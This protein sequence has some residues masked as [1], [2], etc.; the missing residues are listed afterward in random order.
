MRKETL[1]PTMLT[2]AMMTI[3]QSSAGTVSRL[4]EIE[5]LLQTA[6]ATDDL[7]AVKLRLAECVEKIREEAEAVA[8]LSAEAVADLENSSDEGDPSRPESADVDF[9]TGLPDR[10]VAEKELRQCAASNENAFAVIFIA[11]QVQLINARFG[12]AAG[13]QVLKTAKAHIEQS[14]LPFDRLYRW[15]GPSFL[16]LLK[17]LDAVESVR[18]EVSR[19]ATARLET[20]VEM[21][22]KSVLIPIGVHSAV[23]AV[24]S[25]LRL[26]THRID[27]LVA[28]HM[29]KAD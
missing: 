2:K 22:N 29:P 25:P 26:L 16:A 10:S 11:E 8:R 23:F 9:T 15:R 28:S 14:L 24:A 20:M 5:K 17:R 6:A 7:R 12:Y 3:S 18:E 19:I 4:K 21:G 13:D 27:A 1:V